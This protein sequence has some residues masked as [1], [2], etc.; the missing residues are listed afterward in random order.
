MRSSLKNT[1][2]LHLSPGRVWDGQVAAQR[3][4]SGDVLLSEE[5][6]AASEQRSA[7]EGT[8]LTGETR[9][10]FQVN[11]AIPGRPS[12]SCFINEYLLDLEGN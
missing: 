8:L 11:N 9:L 12:I 1:L 3:Q 4:R 7:A 10:L 6:A 2:S 5:P